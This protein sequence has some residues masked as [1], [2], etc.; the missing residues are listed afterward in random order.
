[1]SWS[2]TCGA[3]TARRFAAILQAQ[4]SGGVARDQDHGERPTV[5][6]VAGGTMKIGG[7]FNGQKAEKTCKKKQKNSRDRR[8]TNPR[9]SRHL[10]KQHSTAKSWNVCI[11]RDISHA[12]TMNCTRSCWK[13]MPRR[14]AYRLGSARS[15]RAWLRLTA[16][17]PLRSL[18]RTTSKAGSMQRVR[19]RNCRIEFLCNLYSILTNQRRH[20]RYVPRHESIHR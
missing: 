10:S 11:L 17:S 16:R 8:H 12:P 7:L 9:R 6:V 1:M 3:R 14:E 5:N 4:P 2:D 19:P 15:P 20:H 13:S 18:T